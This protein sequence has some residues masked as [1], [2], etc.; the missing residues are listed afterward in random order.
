MAR[1]IENL[2]YC[3]TP[4]YLFARDDPDFKNL[5]LAYQQ[6]DNRHRWTRRPEGGWH[7]HADR[8]P[9]ARVCVPRAEPDVEAARLAVLRVMVRVLAEA[10]QPAAEVP[11]FR[12]LGSFLALALG[13]RQDEGEGR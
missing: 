5:W 4:A 7:C 1:W 13:D 8:V 10:S 9:L 6:A 12:A 3:G 11:C 2:I